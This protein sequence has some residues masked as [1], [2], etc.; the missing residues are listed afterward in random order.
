MKFIFNNNILPYS[1]SIKGGKNPVVPSWKTQ[2][3][4]RWENPD[5]FFITSHAHMTIQLKKKYHIYMEFSGKEDSA[6]KGE[7][8]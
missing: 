5:I 1:S 8:K 3:Q 6:N 2:K 4:K 7:L